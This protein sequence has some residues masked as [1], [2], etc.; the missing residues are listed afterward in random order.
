MKL[1]ELIR[2][3]YS[4]RNYKPTGV[5]QEKLDYIMECVRLAPSACNKQPWTFRIVTE[6]EDR[7]KLSQ[8][9]NR[10]WFASAPVMIIASIL[11]DEEWVRGDGKHHGDIDIAIAVEHL[12]LAATEQGL[13][14]CWVCN[15]DAERCKT[16]LGLSDHEEPAVLI[17]LGYPADEPKDKKRKA[18]NEIVKINIS[19]GMM[20]FSSFFCANAQE[21]VPG[22]IIT[23]QNNHNW[24]VSHQAIKTTLESSRLFSLD[25]AISPSQGEDMTTFSVDFSKYK[26]VVLDYNGDRWSSAMNTAFMDYV[27]NGGGVVVYHAADNAFADWKEYNEMIALGGWDGRDEASGP[28]FYWK[29]GALCEDNSPGVGGSHGFR[30]EYVLECRTAS[31]PIIKGL[32]VR[33]KH[34]SDE[35][36]DRMRGPG[37]I[38]DLLY[39]AFSSPEQK[40]SGR[41]EPLIFTVEHG[42]G[43]IFHIMIGHCGDSLEDNPA[44]QCAGFQTLLLRGAE[45]CA[46]GKVS[47]PVPKDFPTADKISLRPHYRPDR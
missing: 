31:H 20:L 27:R 19:A 45:W 13:G 41:E 6:E 17:P 16:L 10:E 43:R 14:T 39:T 11:H 26:L 3:R 36:Y 23:G 34:A 44:M 32:P 5:E 42:K 38:K 24:P 7:R 30:H 40:G 4:C 46:T 47:Q 28:Y 12:C 8:C 15:F 22:V 9:Y 2:N 25:V 29:D 21:P 35:L 37:G 33:W 1:L 18:I